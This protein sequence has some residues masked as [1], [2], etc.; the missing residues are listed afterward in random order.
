MRLISFLTVAS[1][2]ATAIGCSSDPDPVSTSGAKVIAPT[3]TVDGKSYAQQSALWWQW[4]L[5]I[6]KADNPIEGKACN[7]SQSGNVFFLAGT[8]DGKA[9]TRSCTIPSG[10]TLFF[11][12]VNGICYPCHE[13]EGCGT[14][15]TKA[16][17]TECAKMPALK[18][19]EASVDGVALTGLDQHKFTSDQ[20]SWKAPTS[21]DPAFAC[22]GPIEAN[23]CGIPLGDRFG[24]S[25]GY[26]VAL[27][28]LSK[29][30]HT[31]KFKAVIPGSGGDPDFVQDVT[32]DLTIE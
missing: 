9:A 18:A 14:S 13:E 7:K 20:F 10:K 27:E 31:L 2:L 5:S 11:P 15:K 19:L 1:A 22:M 6:P 23:T 26:W 4:A 21:G 16:E 17:L 3:A 8:A 25:E 29:G 28:P 12:L 30:K 32:Y 24:V